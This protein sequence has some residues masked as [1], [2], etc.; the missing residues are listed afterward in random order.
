MYLKLAFQQI[1]IQPYLHIKKSHTKLYPS[2]TIIIIIHLNT[3]YII[4]TSIQPVVID[5]GKVKILKLIT[6]SF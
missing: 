6:Y 2:Y 1:S 4:I 3:M 5:A